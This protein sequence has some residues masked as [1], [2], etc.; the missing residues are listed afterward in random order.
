VVTAGPVMT[1]SGI[2]RHRRGY[3]RDFLL[4]LQKIRK[5]ACF[6]KRMHVFSLQVLH[7]RRK[8]HF[9]IG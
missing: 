4:L 6:F 5:H 3:G 7:S 8:L 1:A 2:A 9:G